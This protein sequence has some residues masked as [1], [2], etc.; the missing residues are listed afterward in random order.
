MGGSSIQ[1]FALG[2]QDYHLT[3][4]PQ[5]T[6]F[7]TV[8]KRHTN[9]T[10]DIRRIFFSGETPTFGSTEAIAIIKRDG[11]LLSNIYL[12]ATVTGTTDSAGSYTVN[13]FGN[14]LIK[15]VDFDIGGY[16]ID[17][18]YSQWLQI[19]DEL[20]DNICENR[21]TN[22]NSSKGGLDNTLNLTSAAYDSY[23]INIHNRINGDCPLIF[24][25]TG[26]NGSASAG[27]YTKKFIVPLKFWF[28][29]NPGLYLPL[30]ALYNHEVK[31]KFDFEEKHK[32]IG[33]SANINNMSITFK[34]YG[35]F[36]HLED[37]EKRRFSQSNHEYI[38]EQVQLNNNGPN[39]TS[40]TVGDLST[41]LVKVDYEL[42]FIHPIKYFVW[43]IVNEGTATI[44]ASSNPGQ[45]PCY[46]VSMCSNSIYGN[47]GND[48]T[49]EILLDGTERE[50]ELPLMY[51]TRLYPKKYCKNVPELDRIGMYSFA[52]NPFNIEPSGTCNFSKINDKNIKIAF[53]N[54]IIA[55]ISDKELYF[56]GVNYNVLVI[57]DGMAVTR[58]T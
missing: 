46:F 35:E 33:N 16:I 2:P 3:A 45:G 14:S 30:A 5:I 32:L 17:T 53:A 20:T 26:K 52:L 22:S 48:G 56:F 9:Y 54:N 8:F 24:G 51:Y 49:V 44:S 39:T 23:D 42:N 37:E 55:N 4:N 31:L 12:E 7:K 50:P 1:L 34:I 43:A 58:Y 15:K 28:T 36:I 41:Q 11:D 27:T 29:K 40:S 19:Y 38:I 57:T 6:F 10:K 18:H 25:G 47:D 21:E 13:H